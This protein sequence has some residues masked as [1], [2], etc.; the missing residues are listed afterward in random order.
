MI[1]LD[2]I[3]KDADISISKDVVLERLTSHNVSIIKFYDFYL[4]HYIH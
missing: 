2:T 4:F 1:L 3:Q